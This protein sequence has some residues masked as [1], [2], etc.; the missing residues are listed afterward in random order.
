MP[1]VR[2]RDDA[3]RARQLRPRDALGRPLPYGSAGV[4]QIPDLVASPLETVE[5][6]RRLIDEGRAFSAHEVLES[7]WKRGPVEER[8]LWQGL[9][10]LCVAITHAARGNQ[11]GA[12]RVLQRAQDGLARYQD[13]DGPTYGVDLTRAWEQ[14]RDSVAAQGASRLAPFSA[15]SGDALVG[16]DAPASQTAGGGDPVGTAG[17]ADE[18][19]WDGEGGHAPPHIRRSRLIDELARASDTQRA[20]LWDAAVREFGE[21]GASRIWQEGLSSSDAS[22]T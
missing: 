7:Q 6:A 13:N 2:D 16:V 9:A 10:Q 11:V 21:D 15:T 5:L 19:R 4:P 12:A 20:E 18:D 3:G 1:E 17:S 22:G 8:D 14:A